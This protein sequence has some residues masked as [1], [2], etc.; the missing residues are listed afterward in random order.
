[1][2]TD[3]TVMEKRSLKSVNA[4]QAS[5]WCDAHDMALT[6]TESQSNWKLMGDFSLFVLQTVWH[7]HKQG[8]NYWKTDANP[9]SRSMEDGDRPTSSRRCWFWDFYFQHTVMYARLS[10][11]RVDISHVL[12][13][14]EEN[15]HQK[16][17]S[18]QNKTLQVFFLWTIQMANILNSGNN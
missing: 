1:M 4:K 6:V 10:C 5:R 12:L 13:R 15:M 7:Q 9:C 11:I 17:M 2:K 16:K 8:T 14:E 3:E 18:N